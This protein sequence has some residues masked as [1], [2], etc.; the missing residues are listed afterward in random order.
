MECGTRGLQ[1][2][3]LK[4]GGVWAS[5]QIPIQVH[6]GAGLRVFAQNQVRK[7][8]ANSDLP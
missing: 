6:R 2:D 5:A 8:N 1:R 7:D 4:K 3:V